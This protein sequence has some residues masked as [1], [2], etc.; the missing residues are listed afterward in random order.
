M[1]GIAPSGP[2]QLTPVEVGGGVTHKTGTELPYEESQPAHSNRTDQ[3]ITATA[4]S[5]LS[6]ES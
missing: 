3:R 4:G 1:E 2:H 6:R 5:G